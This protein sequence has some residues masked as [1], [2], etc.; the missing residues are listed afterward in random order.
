MS[1]NSASK[2][3]SQ[4]AVAILLMAA[5][6]LGWL[7]SLSGLML[8]WMS[9]QP[10]K[11]TATEIL[12]VTS[13]ALEVSSQTI[14][15]LE[16][17]LVQAE[18]SLRQVQITLDNFSAVISNTS[19]VLETVSQVLG[20]ELIRILRSTSTGLEGLEKTSRLID[21]TLGFISSIPFIGG[22]QYQP[23]VAL[24]ESVASIRKDL[25][26]MPPAMDEVSSQL[27]QTAAGLQPLPE[28]MDNLTGQLAAIQE[29][30][31]QS[32]A[33]LNEY[34]RIVQTYQS[35]L[36]QLK[37]NLPALITGA[38]AALSA[39]LVWIALAQVGL[40]SQG[41]ERLKTA[42]SPPT[43]PQYSEESVGQP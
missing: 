28:A 36:V 20:D 25:E 33:Q 21:S 3:F 24:A 26:G 29:N 23:E 30:L 10:V 39:L 41:M 40:F 7:I 5:A 12:E 42:G 27:S 19:L 14:V 35:R 1:L 15:L 6:G 4:K 11:T 34:R 16:N 13:G 38:Y 17:S 43:P 32:R 9:Y 22:N 2:I 37:N 31:S 8:L 18:G